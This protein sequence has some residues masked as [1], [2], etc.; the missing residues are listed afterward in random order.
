MGRLLMVDAATF[1]AGFLL[2]LVL[3]V[4]GAFVA[5]FFHLRRQTRVAADHE[6]DTE[7]SDLQRDP[8]NA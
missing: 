1:S 6:L 7:W 5:F 8:R 2:G 3:A 4:Q